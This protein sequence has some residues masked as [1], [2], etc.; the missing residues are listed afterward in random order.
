MEVTPMTEMMS[1]VE[2]TED[3]NPEAGLDGSDE[4]LT[5]QLVDRAK[6]GGLHSPVRAMC[7]SS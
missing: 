4:Q 7:C 2:N 5:N 6:A 1:A 3:S